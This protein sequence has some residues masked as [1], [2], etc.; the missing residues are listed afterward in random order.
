[1]EYQL[2]R[3]K[4]KYTEDLQKAADNPDIAKW[5]TDEFPSPY[6]IEDA[7]D[8]INAQLCADE[9][10]EFCRAVVIDGKAVGCVGIF[11][12]KGIYSRNAELGYWLA[13]PYWRKGIM[14]SAVKEMCEKAFEKY[15]L[16]R[17]YA[18]PFADNTASRQLLNSCG[19]NLDCI[20]RKNVTKNGEILDSCIYSLYK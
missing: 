14:S 18:I 19:F 3:W 20:I 9:D 15:N 13:E 5:M 1:M 4:E 6:S 11:P 2:L 17:I 8:F 12:Q 10:N 16:I 7:E